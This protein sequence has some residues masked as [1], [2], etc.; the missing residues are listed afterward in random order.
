MFKNALLI[1]GALLL[2]GCATPFYDA[3]TAGPM[4]EQASR[5][6]AASLRAHASCQIAFA[7]AGAGKA[8]F[9]PGACAYTDTTLHLYSWDATR[10]RYR[11]EVQLELAS[12]ESFSKAKLA[13]WSQ[14]QLPVDGGR[15]VFESK[16]VDAFQQ[17]M[18]KAGVKEVPSL[19]YVSINAPPQPTTIYIPVY[20]GG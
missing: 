8:D 2:C 20:V 13:M 11:R 17:V 16:S 6:P 7:P 1:A 4:L 19:G 14:L 10:K 5:L 18:L 9:I 12:I 3:R 15:I